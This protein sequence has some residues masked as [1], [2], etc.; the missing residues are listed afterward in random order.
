[1]DMDY[2]NDDDEERNI[3][4]NQQQQPIINRMVS[5]K[6][7]GSSQQALMSS[8]Q[9]S[10]NDIE[11]DTVEELTN[12]IDGSLGSYNYTAD[13]SEQQQHEHKYEEYDFSG[14]VPES[15]ADQVL[16]ELELVSDDDD[17]DLL[18]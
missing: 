7:T 16:N 1:M 18:I 9:S 5:Q 13:D 14:R 8:Q 6:S 10:D 2:E 3:I 4:L 15:E 17:E 11:A 12:E